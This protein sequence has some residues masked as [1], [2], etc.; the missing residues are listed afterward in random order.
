MRDIKRIESL[1]K[2]IVDKGGVWNLYIDLVNKIK[3]ENGLIETREYL[4]GIYNV[5]EKISWFTLRDIIFTSQQLQQ[6]TDVEGKE[7]DCIFP[8]DTHV[9]SI[10]NRLAVDSNGAE[11]LKNAILKKT[12]DL[13]DVAL[14]NSGMTFYMSSKED[15]CFLWDKGSA[16]RLWELSFRRICEEA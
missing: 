12:K 8:R 7:K 6:K 1:F 10:L 2:H 15:N 13:L 16:E 5:G 3:E 11:N 14:V 4:D 9:N